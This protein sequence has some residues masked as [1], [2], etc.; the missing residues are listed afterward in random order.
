MAKLTKIEAQQKV[1]D[2]TEKL[3]FTKKDLKDVTVGYKD[4]IKEL[5]GEIEAIIEEFNGDVQVPAVKSKKTD[6]DVD[7]SS[8]ED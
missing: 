3:I 1:Y 7:N 8:T 4:T 6:V 5:Q 2:L